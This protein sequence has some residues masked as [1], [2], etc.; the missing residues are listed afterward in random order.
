MAAQESH[1]WR[2]KL[3]YTGSFIVILALIFILSFLFFDLISPHPSP[4]IGLIT[5]L[6]LPGFLLVGILLGWG[7]LLIARRR[8]KHRLGAE[9]TA[10][11]LP[12]IDLNQPHHRHVLLTLGTIIALT[13]P[14]IGVMSYEGYQYSDSDK[15]CGLVCHSVMD[16]QYTAHLHSPHARV[17]CAECHKHPF[18]HSTDIHH[19]N[20]LEWKKQIAGKHFRGYYVVTT[21]L[22]KKIKNT[23]LIRQN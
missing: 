5:Y 18:D 16:P 13:I 3:T 8:L 6:I 12:D 11:Y 10:Q 14:F 23:F 15:F 4:Y 20:A 21:G 19:Q 7:G 9:A 17:Q 2:N 1:L 22:D